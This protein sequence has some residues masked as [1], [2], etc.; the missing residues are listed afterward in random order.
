MDEL[1]HR[2][3]IGHSLLKPFLS[4]LA[5]VISL[6]V[7][8]SLTFVFFSFMSAD[9]TASRGSQHDMMPSVVTGHSSDDRPL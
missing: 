5:F 1:K 3:A 8:D 9:N 6:I 2:T 4:I 7:L